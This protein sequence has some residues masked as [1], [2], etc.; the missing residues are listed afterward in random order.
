MMQ[1][2]EVKRQLASLR[3]DVQA[4]GD[5]LHRLRQ[6]DVRA[7]YTEQIR[8]VLEE[9]VHQHF[10]PGRMKGRTCRD[11]AGCAIDVTTFIGRALSAFKE[12]GMQAGMKVVQDYER[13]LDQSKEACRG[14]LEFKKGIAAEIHNYLDIS[15]GFERHIEPDGRTFPT[16]AAEVSPEEVEAFLAPLSSAV[17]V[18]LLLLLRKEGMSLAEMSR[19]TGLVKGHLQ[20]HLR[21]LTEAGLVD[22]D[23]RSKVY[24]LSGRGADVL[25]GVID[26]MRKASADTIAMP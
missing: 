3:A 4:L 17:R 16:S 22:F 5:D 26:L 19:N 2:D 6:E 11:P 1:D 25:G 10:A 15:L 20:F 14:C 21:S 24:S 23:R 7:V 12:R 8:S 18:R 13:H 9:R